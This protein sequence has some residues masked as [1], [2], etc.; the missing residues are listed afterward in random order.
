[1][2]QGQSC[3][4]VHTD[5][6]ICIAT[7]E[8]CVLRLSINAFH[9]VGWVCELAE[10]QEEM[11]RSGHRATFVRGTES[12]DATRF[13]PRS[14]GLAGAWRRMRHWWNPTTRVA[15][16][17][18]QPF[19][20]RTHWR[21]DDFIS[22]SIR[23]S[24]KWEPFETSLVINLLASGGVF[25]DIGA[26]IGWFSVIAAF[27]VGPGGAV[28]SFEP[29][30]RNFSLLRLNTSQ[31]GLSNV[32][33]FRAAVSDRD[34]HGTLFASASNLGD[35]Q[36]DAP[37]PERVSRRVR[38][39]SLSGLLKSSGLLP[40]LI[41]IDTQG[42]EARILS[43]LVENSDAAGRCPILFEYWPHGIRRSG[44][45]VQLLIDALKRLGPDL[46]IVDEINRKL[47]PVSVDDLAWRAENDLAPET[48]HFTN[49]LYYPGG[50]QIPG[51]LA[52]SVAPPW[53]RKMGKSFLGY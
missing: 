12:G 1:M 50:L 44:A 37:D 26:N 32:R 47:H 40:D 8:R 45:S 35:H 29:D 20:M 14:A 6:N 10:S 30:E 2:T 21:R 42:S 51:S 43:N 5:C 18:F 7:G 22:T 9:L 31:N 33:L 48:T 3:I 34:G 23:E 15:I 36:L 46:F 53:D 17:G 24:G 39:M 28:L 19:T 49:L 52:S 16:S 38:V 25:F 11:G 4:I 41:K 27:A 13:F